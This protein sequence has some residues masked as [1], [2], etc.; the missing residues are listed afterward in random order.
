MRS[1]AY[2]SRTYWGSCSRLT[3]CSLQIKSSTQGMASLSN[4]RSAARKLPRAVI[5]RVG[6][7]VRLLS[8]HPENLPAAF[9]NDLAF[10]LNCWRIDPVFCIA[11]PLSTCLRGGQN[12]VA[13]R[14]S[15]AQHYF[16][17]EG[18]AMKAIDTN[19]VIAG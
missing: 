16:L 19:T 14:F 17:R 5:R 3:L 8:Q 1:R 6:A 2:R 4:H 10:F 13:T 7:A 12:S 9:G 11:D 15:F 18:S